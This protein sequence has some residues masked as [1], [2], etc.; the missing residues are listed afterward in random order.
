MVGA[1]SAHAAFHK[2]AYLFGITVRKTAAK[3]DWSH[4]VEAMAA[5]VNSNTVLIV[6]PP[7]STLG[8][9]RPDPGDR[10]IGPIGRRQPPRR[11]CCAH[12]NSFVVVT[13][14]TCPT[15][16]APFSVTGTYR[17]EAV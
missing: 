1:E 17:F 2:A 5:V 14:N 12:T 9:G 8:C 16:G 7:R 3:P 11:C 13:R 15:T 4:D 10:R 6:G